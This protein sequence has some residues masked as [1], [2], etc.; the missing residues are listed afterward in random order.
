VTQT[1]DGSL[2]LAGGESYLVG[3][4]RVA[5]RVNSA[6]LVNTDGSGNVEFAR[7]F[8]E[9]SLGFDRDDRIGVNS[10]HQTEDDGFVPAG[11]DVPGLADKD[12]FLIKT[13]SNGNL[14]V[15][16]DVR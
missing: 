14:V 10:I 16:R 3:T 2:A 9:E 15:Q 8:E 12:S 7:T 5:P 11:V 13:D 1:S 4:G 6:W